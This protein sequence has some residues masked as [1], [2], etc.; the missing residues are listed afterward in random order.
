MSRRF[1]TRG[2][3]PERSRMADL[4]AFLFLGGVMKLFLYTATRPNRGSPVR[5]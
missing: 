3:D 5:A 2:V 4:R 1:S